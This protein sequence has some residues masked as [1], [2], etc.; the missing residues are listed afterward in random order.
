M[1]SFLKHPTSIST[2]PDREEVPTED[3][4]GKNIKVTPF[5]V[6][7]FISTGMY[8]IIDK[9]RDQEHILHDINASHKHSIKYYL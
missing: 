5:C 1:V 8:I 4:V 9:I 6:S 7:Y 2:T 3:D